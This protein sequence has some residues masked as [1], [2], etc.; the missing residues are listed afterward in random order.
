MDDLPVAPVPEPTDRPVEVVYCAGWDATK[1]APVSPMAESVARTQDAAGAQWAAVMFVDGVART[2]LEVCWQAHHAELWNVDDAGRRY[3]GVAYR[4][5]PDDRL[6]LFEVR[7]WNENGPD[8]PE[9]DGAE[10]TLRTRVNRNEDGANPT[11]TIH[12]EMP[13]GSTLQLN[14]T[15]DWPEPARPPDNLALPSVG[16]WPRLA[17]L[18]GRVT[19][20]PGPATVPSRFPWRPPQPLQPQYVTELVTAGTRFRK[21]DGQVLTVERVDAGTIRLPSGRLVVGDPGWLEYDTDAV[22]QADRVPPGEYQ[23]DV[24]QANTMTVACRVAVTGA[25]VASWHLAMRVG[26]SALELGDG[27]FYGNPVDTATIGLVDRDGTKAYS[28]S[29]IEK[30]MSDVIDNAP[31]RTISNERTRTDL[32]V[33][34]GWT[35]GSYPVWL[36]RAKDGEISCFVVDFMSPDLADAKPL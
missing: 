32:V 31:S 8:S 17:G 34:P 22:P 4:R 2:V 26:D 7:S 24:F 25:P 33:V 11:F 21:P 15:T 14:Q 20:R 28:Q 3:R 13:D 18:T 30:V 12:A 9:F 29:E 27:E 5:W 16:G 35:D 6:R 23:V 36:G 19:V 1:R 10:P